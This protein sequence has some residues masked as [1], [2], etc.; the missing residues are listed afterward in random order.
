[1]TGK[2]IPMMLVGDE[3]IRKQQALSKLT[4][5]SLRDCKV[6]IIDSTT[7][8]NLCP[9]L[10]EIDLRANLL[11][12]WEN[13][14]NLGKSI[15]TLRIL[16][17]SENILEPLTE[18]LANQ[19]MNCFPELRTLIISHTTL[20]WSS[21]TL[22]YKLC[23]NLE[24]LHACHNQI[25]TLVSQPAYR[26]T[27]T[28]T[29]HIPSTT[30]SFINNNYFPKLKVLNISDNPIKEWGQ[31]YSLSYLSS[32]Q[33]LLINDCH[34]TDIWIDCPNELP[35][36]NENIVLPFNKLEQLSITGNKFSSLYT[37]DALDSF[38]NLINLRLTHT[39]LTMNTT[40]LITNHY[41]NNNTSSFSSTANNNT[42]GPSEARQVI[43]ARV[44]R[45][46]ML[47]GSEVR[48][49]EREDAEKAYTKK[50]AMTFA[51]NEKGK[52]TNIIDIFG[53]KLAPE[54]AALAQAAHIATMINSNSNGVPSTVSNVTS[55]PVT[56][57]IG[58]TSSSSSSSTVKTTLVMG[59]PTGFSKGSDAGIIRSQRD[60][61]HSVFTYSP[62]CL[63]KLSSY[64]NNENSY[65]YISSLDPWSLGNT[66]VEQAGKIQALFPRYFLLAAR[67]DIH[68]PLTANASAASSIAS[69]VASLTLRSMAGNS[70]MMEPQ[71]KK[72]PVS[73]TIGSLK[74]LASR[75]FK[76]DIALQRLS[77]R[78]S[79]SSYPSL[80]DDDSKP[81]SYYAVSDGGEVLIEE[82]DPIEAAR[83][84]QEIERQ[85]QLRIDEQEKQ[86]EALRKAQEMSVTAVRRAV[87]VAA[88]VEDDRI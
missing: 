61:N 31:I 25:T 51:E 77:F 37:I 83:Q 52:N 13:L 56:S 79:P 47:N 42:L 69:T 35:F 29:I 76:C 64:S 45:L 1:M 72:L 2:A 24:E 82:I 78:D 18:T 8:I 17:I 7:L 15:P 63:W 55:V 26:D 65:P 9:K 59:T 14:Y 75:L 3:K 41:H 46:T 40:T 68:A 19:Y 70:C 57:N 85:K 88:K 67:Y 60:M 54:A 38:I 36:T 43:V 50:I 27:I 28:N 10:R 20:S 81:L 11:S 23:P 44:P 66:A 5:A 74:Q 21:L 62:Y 58:S 33:W 16:N 48:P 49:R 80:M 34:I 73:M 6:S 53:A 22:L 86:G 4:T 12:T 84:A 30:D 32:L 71:V 39:D 87:V